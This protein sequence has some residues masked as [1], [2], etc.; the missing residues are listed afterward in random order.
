MT[1]MK[2]GGSQ[3]GVISPQDTFTVSGDILG[4]HSWW[5]VISIL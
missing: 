2:D 4:H 3:L 1:H 5:G